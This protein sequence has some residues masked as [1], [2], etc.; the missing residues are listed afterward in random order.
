MTK[1]LTG[2][3]VVIDKSAMAVIVKS[4]NGELEYMYRKGAG[5]SE[6]DQ[7]TPDFIKAKG[8]ALISKQ[9]CPLYGTV[10][11]RYARVL[12]LDTGND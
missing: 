1:K 5:C 6:L 2:N 11:Y 4:K 7:S 8:L 9:I 10:T 3:D 12:S